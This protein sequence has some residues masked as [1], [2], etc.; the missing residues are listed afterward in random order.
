MNI[1]P[2]EIQF[3][4]VLMGSTFRL[5]DKT[6]DAEWIKIDEEHA[7]G[8]FKGVAQPLT[9]TFLPDEIVIV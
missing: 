7:E 1:K 4:K 9:L 2:V 3:E 5:L 8:F 6:I